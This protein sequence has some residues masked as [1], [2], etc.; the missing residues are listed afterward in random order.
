MP[1]VVS[2]PTLAGPPCITSKVSITR[3]VRQ[4]QGFSG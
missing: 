4:I 3:D 1:A 2:R